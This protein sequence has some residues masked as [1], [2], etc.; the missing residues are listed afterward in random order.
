MINQTAKKILKAL[1]FDGVEVEAF[2]QMADLKRLDP[3]KVF[4]KKID[5]C[6]LGYYDNG[7]AVMLKRCSGKEQHMGSCCEQ[8]SNYRS[9]ITGGNHNEYSYWYFRIW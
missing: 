2:R 4:Y 7:C 5:N 9:E 1:S 6:R 8:N 3:M